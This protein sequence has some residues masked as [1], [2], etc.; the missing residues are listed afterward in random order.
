MSEPMST[1][2]IA[3]VQPPDDFVTTM[4]LTIGCG[5]CDG[6]MKLDDAFKG[7]QNLAVVV[8]KCNKCEATTVLHII[9]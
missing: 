3:V 5:K 4:G 6:T 9:L 8:M 2:E 1:Y 7:S